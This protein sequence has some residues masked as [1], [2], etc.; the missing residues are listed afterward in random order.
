M[1]VIL[2]VT[3]I[4]RFQPLNLNEIDRLATL[5]LLDAFTVVTPDSHVYALQTNAP[6]W[7]FSM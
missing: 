4:T 7:C 6:R 2:V 5:Q 3:V 1:Y